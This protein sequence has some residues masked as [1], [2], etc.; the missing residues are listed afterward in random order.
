MSDA[1]SRLTDHLGYWLRAVSNRVSQSFAVRLEAEGVSVAEWV[2]LRS[3]FDAALPPSRLAET[4][5]LTRGA[6]TKLAD[7]LIARGL[8]ARRASEADG[9]AQTLALTRKGLALTPRLAAIA[10][11]NDTAF[12][13]PVS[14]ADR[15]AL[16]RLMQEL[17]AQH[18]ITDAPTA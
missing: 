1:P 12:F 11:A 7:R 15:R 8:L 10:D 3:L 14:P 4:M 6:I 5:G 17:S 2:M 9:R 13:G 18:G 16:L